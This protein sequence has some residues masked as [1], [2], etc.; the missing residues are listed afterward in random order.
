[1]KFINILWQIY[2][3]TFDLLAMPLLKLSNRRHMLEEGPGHRSAIIKSRLLTL[4]T[5]LSKDTL[6]CILK[7]MY[8][9]PNLIKKAF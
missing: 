4:L 7:Y 8:I 6:I 9:F 2:L 3:T 1:M 5:S